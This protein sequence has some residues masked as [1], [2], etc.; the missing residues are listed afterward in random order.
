[1]LDFEK[2]Y[3]SKDINF[4]AGCDEA[5]R[6]P[7]AGPVVCAAV[8]FPK[9]FISNEINDSKQLSKKKREEL[10][11][12]ILEHALAYNIQIIDAK[13]IDEINIL[14]ASRLGMAKAVKNLNH[15]VDLI[16]TDYMKLYDFDVPV[17][18]LV[19]GDAKAMCVAA[20]SI[21]AKVTRDNIMDEL[22]K[23]YPNYHFAKTKGY[24]TK[25]SI[26]AVMEFGPIEGVHRYS[27]KPVQKALEIKLF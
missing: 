4:I 5:G 18:D 13:T 24:P 25:E 16:I 11:N 20:A 27:Y 22:D 21:L 17:I 3:Y 19:K 7:I 14:E 10:F 15:Q 2:K 9:D 26:D 1:M 12:F 6:G 8:I 23:Q